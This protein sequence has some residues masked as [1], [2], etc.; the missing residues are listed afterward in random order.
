M[1]EKF[2][3]ISN[4]LPGNISNSRDYSLIA[5]HF[6]YEIIP[7]QDDVRGFN[8]LTGII[9]KLTQGLF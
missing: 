8:W 3:D 7:A 1:V 9:Q 2:R 5:Y 6:D 4:D